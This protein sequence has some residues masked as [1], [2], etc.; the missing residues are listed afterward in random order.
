ML[1]EEIKNQHIPEIDLSDTTLSQC[2]TMMRMKAHEKR[3]K[4]PTTFLSRYCP[5][6]TPNEVF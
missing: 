1:L 3:T 4:T 2:E 6:V 5:V